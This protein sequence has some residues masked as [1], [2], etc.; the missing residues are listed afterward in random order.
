MTPEREGT[1]T[2]WYLQPRSIFFLVMALLSL[3]FLVLSL[4]LPMGTVSRVGPGVF[5]AL[6]GLL[7]LGASA[8]G[9]VGMRRAAAAAPG[10]VRDPDPVVDLPADEGDET[11][12]RSPESGFLARHGRPL[13]FLVVLLVYPLTVG[14]LGHLP[15]S[16]VVC[17]GVMVLARRRS[18]LSA[19]IWALVLSVGSTFLFAALGVHLPRGVFGF[20]EGFGL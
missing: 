9:F 14:M 15:A 1:A 13:L 20:L 5:P 19:I 4:Q 11:A 18:L 6:A 17:L 7:G 16:F 8:A 3:T 12:S 2:R 10:T